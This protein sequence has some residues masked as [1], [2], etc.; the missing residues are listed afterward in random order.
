MNE[1]LYHLADGYS[2]RV[3]SDLES[4][5]QLRTV[6]DEL[7]ENQKT[8]M[9][10][11]CFDWFRIWIKHFLKDNELFILLLYQQDRVVAIAPLH[12][13]SIFFKKNLKARIV[14]LL[15]NIHSPIKN[16]IY[17]DHDIRVMSDCLLKIFRFFFD[18]YRDWDIMELDSIPEEDHYFNILKNVANTIGFK[19]REYFCYNDWVLEKISYSGCEYLQKRSKNIRKELGKRKRRLQGKGDLRFENGTN[20]NKFDDYIRI[21]NYVREHSWKHPEKDNFFLKELRKSAMEKGWLRF[22]ILFFNNLPISCHIRMNYKNSVYFLESVYDL[23]YSKF[24]PTTILRS[25]LMQYIID[26]ENAGIIHTIRGDEPYKKD[27][28]PTQ[29]QRK[30]MTIFNN[31]LKGRSLAFLMLAILPNIEKHPFLLSAKSKVFQWVKNGF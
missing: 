21:Y 23:E 12:I 11:L 17:K 19:R 15:G 13:K 28:T 22:A 1:K 9:P 30:G 7:L 24:S 27:W 31:N 14:S 6:W 5:Y 2:I 8:H 3:V 16:I 20:K 29:K 4:F 25:E 10:F 26:K 18:V